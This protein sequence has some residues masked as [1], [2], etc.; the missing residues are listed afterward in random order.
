MVFPTSVIAEYSTA[1]VDAGLP[2]DWMIYPTTGPPVVAAGAGIIFNQL[3]VTHP[4]LGIGNK[5][6]FFELVNPATTAKSADGL[7]LA[8]DGKF[9]VT[10]I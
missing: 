7:Q 6:L 5:P 8:T 4:T 1:V 10:P 2:A 9:P 3:Q